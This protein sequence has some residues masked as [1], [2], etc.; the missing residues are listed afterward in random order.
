MSIPEI[1]PRPLYDLVVSE[2]V[3][4]HYAKLMHVDYAYQKTT[5]TLS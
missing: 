4:T 3:G 5:K 1:H 2:D